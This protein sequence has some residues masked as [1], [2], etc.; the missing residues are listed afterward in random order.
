MI[1]LGEHCHT[2]VIPRL[3]K[4]IDGEDPGGISDAVGWK[5]G[6]GFRYYRLAP[7]LLERD[8]WGNWVVNREYNAAMLAEALCKLEGFTYA[9]SETLWW[10]HGHSTER[11]FIW[12]TTQNLSAE[13]LQALAGANSSGKS[14]MLQPLLLLKQ[15]MEASYDPGPLLLDG[16][17]VR[18]SKAEQLLS[19]GVSGFSV[20]VETDAG[21]S[22]TNRYSRKSEGGFELQAMD[23]VRA[24]DGSSGTFAL[25]TTSEEIIATLPETVRTYAASS[26][27]GAVLAPARSYGLMQ[28][29]V[30]GGLGL[31]EKLM[32]SDIRARDLWAPGEHI[33]RALSALIHVPGLRGNPARSYPRAEIGSGFAG[34]FESYVASLIQH[35]ADSDEE[36]LTGLIQNLRHIG[37]ARYVKSAR[38][39]DTRVE[40][41][42]ARLPAGE[43]FGNTDLVNIVDVG[44]GVSQALPVLSA[45]IAAH[46]GQ[47]VYIEQ[48]ELHLHPLAQSRMADVLVGAARR[49]VRLVV[50]THSDLLL[51]GIQTAVAKDKIAPTDVSLNWFTRDLKTGL[52]AATKAELDENGAF[53][54]WPAH[55]DEVALGAERAY[56]DAV[57]A[58]HIK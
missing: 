39:D 26:K 19:P 5:G 17:H 42:V 21:G 51:R 18:F 9:P 28:I 36:R 57:E 43:Q 22:I 14:S 1:E 32:E 27:A 24:S 48:P 3:R 52:T 37:I 41:Q 33:F 56:L 10:Q 45:L 30:L 46:P 13:Q 6:G 2:H 53:G 54:E 31:A 25:D 49:G 12:V 15:T 29:R 11:D 44:F 7:S 8:R 40:L 20:R 58:R 55:F 47:L 50:E 34:G 35:W 4:V 38:I 23:F 16:P